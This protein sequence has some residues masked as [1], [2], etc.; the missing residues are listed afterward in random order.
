MLG[1]L[2]QTELPKTWQKILSGIPDYDPFGTAGECEF[3][4]DAARQ[5]LDFFPSYLRHI[6]GPL[7]GEP[8][9]LSP[10]ERSFIANLFGWKRPDGLRRY[11]EAFVLIPRKNGKTSIA[12]GIVLYVLTCDG[13]A[14][15]EIYSAANDRDQARLVFLTVK[16]M[17]QASEELSRYCKIYQHSIVLMNP[18]TGAQTNS[19]YRP[20]SA[21]ANTKYGYNSHLVIN[22]ELHGQKDRELSD[23]LETSTA[24]RAQPLIINITTADYDRPSI[25]NEKY[26]YACKV[27]DGIVPDETFLPVI[28][29]AS[30]TDDWTKPSIWRK[31]NP[32]YGISVRPDYIREKCKKAQENPS[33]ENTFKRLHLNIRTEQDIRWLPLEEW[34]ANDGKVNE[35]ELV[36]RPCF[37]GMDLS[38]TR[39]ITATCLLFPPEDESGLWQAIWRLYLPGDNVEQR[40]RRDKVPYWTWAKKGLIKLIPGSVVDYSVVRADLH[41]DYSHFAVQEIA[42]DRWNFEA[43]RQQFISEGIAEEKFVSFGEGF[44]SMSAPMKEMEKLILSRRLAYNSHPVIQ[45]M[46]S[47]VAAELDAAGNIKPSKA[48]S[49]GRID[50]IVALIMALGRAMVTP[51]VD[52]SVGILV[53]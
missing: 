53:L 46:A 25:C 19:F 50:G 29:E 12:A 7:A 15:A 39:D 3:D 5:A 51:I 2:T 34:R 33:F 6:K 36:G 32:N 30:A 1:L 10:W 14:G 4:R 20:I 40:E 23:V 8:F 49:S 37:I 48:K 38:S 35:E 47:N 43:L 11:K 18:E 22:D 16:G 9:A 27:R 31:A 44:A 26:D 28:Y 52:E 24:A 21:E 45:W 42:F 13:E 41:K 17:V